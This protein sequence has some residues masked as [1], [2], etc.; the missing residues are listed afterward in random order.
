MSVILREL[1]TEE[2]Y[3]GAIPGAVRSFAMLRMT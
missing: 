3:Y 2:S 1:A